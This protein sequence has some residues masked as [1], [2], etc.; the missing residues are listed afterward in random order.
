MISKPFKLGLIVR[1]DDTGLG[2][3]TRNLCYM[4]KPDRVLYINSKPFNGNGQHYDWYEGFTGITS[5]GF[6]DNNTVR[7]FLNGLTH[8]ITAETCYSYELIRL[9]NASGIKTFNVVNYEFCD[10]LRQS[11]PM[12]YKWLMPS[13]WKNEEMANK[14][15]NVEYLPPPIFTND[16][17]EAREINF[18]RSGGYRRFVHIVGKQAEHDRNGTEDLLRALEYC[19]SEFE[20]VIKSQYPI[21]YQINDRRVLFDI[22]NKS[23]EKLS[24]LYKDFDA[25]IMPRRYG[26]LCLPMNEALCSGLPVIMTDISPNNQVLPKEWLVEAK[27]KMQFM[28]RTMIDC[29]MSNLEDLAERIDQFATMAEGALDEQKQ[30]AFEIGFDNYDVDSLREKYKGV[31]EDER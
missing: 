19:Q 3:Q 14:F 1:G 28:T 24:D 7:K 12:P 30:K 17:K 10:H 5:L 6:P 2:N 9:A 20:L 22:G 18:G 4:L 31:L 16:F 26:G 15:E 27:V 11:L 13:Y 29:Y 25:L 8:V 21:P 23:G